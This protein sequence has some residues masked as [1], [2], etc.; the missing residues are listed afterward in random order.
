SARWV[1][2]LD[3]EAL[4][5]AARTHRLLVT[6]EENTGLGGFGAAVL[7]CLHD[8][9]LDNVPVLRLAVPD[10]FV[11]HGRMDVLLDEIGLT[12][13]GVRGAVHGRLLDLPGAPMPETDA[14][15]RGRTPR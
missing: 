8:L 5:E 2:P 14:S 13:E 3:V 7:E 6:I 10:C 4:A 1:K 12:P 11:T 9:S 15:P